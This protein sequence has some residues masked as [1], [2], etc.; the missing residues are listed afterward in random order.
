MHANWA[1]NAVS[2]YQY[3][4]SMHAYVDRLSTRWQSTSAKDTIRWPKCLR[5]RPVILSMRILP[6]LLESERPMRGGEDFDATSVFDDPYWADLLRLLQAFWARGR[7]ERL[8][9]LANS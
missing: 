9:Q 7:E 2:L 4:G 8:E 6:S 5:C 3:V 1:L